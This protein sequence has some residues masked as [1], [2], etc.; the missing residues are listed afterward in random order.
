[1]AKSSRLSDT[2]RENLVAYLDGELDAKTARLV[3]EQIRRDPNVRT[4][5]DALSRTWEILDF[6]PRAEPSPNFS[7]K[8]L[9]QVSVL[10][11]AV[12]PASR[13]QFRSWALA[14]SWAA[15]VLLAALVGYGSVSFLMERHQRQ[16]AEESQADIDQQLL[17]D[18]RVIENQHL[19]RHVDDIQLLRALDD[20][21]L[22]GDGG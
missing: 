13:S 10:R 8:T 12:A 22:F 7:S 3:E 19:Y 6:L 21:D 20:P 18:L 2:D 14:I 5:F 17:R 1:M 16:A 9:Q 15:A 4:E 11:P